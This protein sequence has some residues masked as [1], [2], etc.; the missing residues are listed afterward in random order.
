[1][2]SCAVVSLSVMTIGA[3]DEG[4]THQ[5]LL[6]TAFLASGVCFV[7]FQLSSSA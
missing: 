6:I 5:V 1:M 4:E 3:A 7:E 2:N